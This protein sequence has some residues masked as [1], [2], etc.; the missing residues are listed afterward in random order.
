MH[1]YK[2]KI[3]NR[4][5]KAVEKSGCGHWGKPAAC[6]CLNTFNKWKNEHK[7]STNTEL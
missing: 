1:A 5:W 3:Y 4:C 6:L 7:G 2:N